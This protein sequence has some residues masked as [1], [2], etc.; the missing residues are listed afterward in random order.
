ML[1]S[2]LRSWGTLLLLRSV[3]TTLCVA[4]QLFSDSQYVGRFPACMS[5][6]VENGADVDARDNEGVTALHWAASSGQ[7]EAV[8]LLIEANAGHSPREIDRDQFTPLDYARI[9]DPETGV[10][11]KDIIE[12]VQ[13]PPEPVPDYYGVH[14][15]PQCSVSFAVFLAQSRLTVHCLCVEGTSKLKALCRSRS[16][17]ILPPRQSNGTGSRSRR[18]KLRARRKRSVL[19]NSQRRVFIKRKMLTAGTAAAVCNLSPRSTRRQL[20]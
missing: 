10:S 16:S 13:R 15:L 6:L 12:Y 11:H 7:I 18:I 19:Q 8:M 3:C 5:V 2:A 9:G 14:V 17:R 20:K 1:C 4:R